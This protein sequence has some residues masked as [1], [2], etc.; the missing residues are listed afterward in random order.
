[1]N[2]KKYS[3]LHL[4]LFSFFSKKL[5]RD[6]GQNWKGANFAYLFL[7]L[8]ICWIAPT[9]HMREQL[10]QSLDST[11][12]LLINQLPDI[13]IKN[14]R[15]EMDQKKPL[16]I[17][18]AGKTVAIIDTTGS[19]NYIA[20]QEVM[21]LL[22]TDKLIIRRGANQF[23]TL[24]LSEVSDFHVNKEIASQ[25]LLS[26]KSAI[27]PLSYGIFLLL[28][29]IFTVLFLI[30]TA[31]VGLILASILKSSLKFSGTL[32]IAVTACTPAIILI[33]ASAAYG[34]AVPGLIYAGVTL[35]YLLVGIMACRKPA[36]KS[37]APQLN[38]SALLHDEDSTADSHAA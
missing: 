31:V 13:H 36:E 34:L 8:A 38:L 20:D 37:N 27:A 23:N 11:Q 1:M 9:L 3:M 2:G 10:V 26:I 24:D 18:L 19:M 28:S 21:A 32:R 33:T 25:W 22:T 15:V 5:Y 35:L 4:P 30:F 14:G 17:T 16:N 29:Y 7:L 12:L 6:V